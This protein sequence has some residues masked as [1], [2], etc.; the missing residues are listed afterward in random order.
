[1]EPPFSLYS[2]AGVWCG[3]HTSWICWHHTPTVG[4]QKMT[5]IIT[6]SQH[7]RVCLPRAVSDPAFDCSSAARKSV[8]SWGPGKVGSLLQDTTLQRGGAE[9]CSFLSWKVLSGGPSTRGPGDRMQTEVQGRPLVLRPHGSPR[10][11]PAGDRG[12]GLGQ[13]ASNSQGTKGGGL[14]NW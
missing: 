13:V 6:V 14:P 8:S 2:H 9:P 3:S 11:S 10:A 1:M 4:L 5:A 7:T 12:P